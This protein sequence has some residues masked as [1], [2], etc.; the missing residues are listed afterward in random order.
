MG[1]AHFSKRDPAWMVETYTKRILQEG[2]PY[3]FT[4]EMFLKLKALEPKGP[5]GPCEADKDL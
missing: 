2:S 5:E 4:R 1:L 3:K